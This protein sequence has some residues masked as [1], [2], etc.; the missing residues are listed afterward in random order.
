MIQKEKT[1][2]ASKAARGTV[3]AAV[4]KG[5]SQSLDLVV[6]LCYDQKPFY[7]ILHSCE[8]ITLVPLT[9]KV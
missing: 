4:L 2:K 7:M 3:K 8:Q 9:K 1:R 5:E 6:V